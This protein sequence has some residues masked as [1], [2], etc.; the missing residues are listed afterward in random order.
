LKQRPTSWGSAIRDC[1]RKF[2]RYPLKIL[3]STHEA[4]TPHLTLSTHVTINLSELVNA[5]V[6]ETH[7]YKESNSVIQNT[8]PK[9][10]AKIKERAAKRVKNLYSGIC[11]LLFIV[12]SL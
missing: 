3:N 9:A 2:N 4:P 11:P 1:V 10:A 6:R 5:Y 12:L 7:S 8:T